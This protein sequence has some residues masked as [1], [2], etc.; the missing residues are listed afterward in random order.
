M[1]LAAAC[2]V[3]VDDYI[4]ANDF[5]FASS[6][7]SSRLFNYKPRSYRTTVEVLRESRSENR[8]IKDFTSFLSLFQENQSII[9]VSYAEF[10]KAL[11]EIEDAMKGFAAEHTALKAVV[12]DECI[13]SYFERGG[14]KVFYNLFFDGEGDVAQVNVSLHD[15]YYSFD[16]DVEQVVRFFQKV[17]ADEHAGFGL[18]R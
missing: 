4:S 3:D 1:A 18:S 7:A 2:P 5:C 10:R 13:L 15:R 17:M 16:G 6:A 11:K 8:L 14:I 9:K 12:D